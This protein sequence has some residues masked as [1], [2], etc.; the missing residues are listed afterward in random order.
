[1]LNMHLRYNTP[2]SWRILFQYKGRPRKFSG[3]KTFRYLVV[4][5]RGYH[6][7]ILIQGIQINCRFSCGRR[8][9]LKRKRYLIISSFHVPIQRNSSYGQTII[10]SINKNRQPKHL[11]Y[12]TLLSTNYYPREPLHRPVTSGTYIALRISIYIL[13]DGNNTRQ[14]NFS[15]I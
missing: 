3:I 11:H 8:S 5:V 15:V 9:R 6:K 4:P 7:V 2:S 14:N 1:M 10:Q 12:K 13:P